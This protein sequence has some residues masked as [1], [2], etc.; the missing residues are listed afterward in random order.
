MIPNKALCASCHA[1]EG[2]DVK[3]QAVGGA[4]NSCTEC[5][6]YHGGD[7]RI[8]EGERQRGLGPAMAGDSDAKDIQRFVT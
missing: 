6:R 5:H 1:P 3:G 8:H 7:T 4:G 2:R